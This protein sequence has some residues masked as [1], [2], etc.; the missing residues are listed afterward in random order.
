MATEGV[1]RSLNPRLPKITKRGS[2]KINENKFQ[3]DILI[4]LQLQ[5]DMPFH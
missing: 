1:G 4:T 3:L 5:G 2:V